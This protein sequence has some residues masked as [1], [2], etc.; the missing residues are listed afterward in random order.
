MNMLLRS[1][2]ILRHYLGI[3]GLAGL[4]LALAGLAAYFLM[5]QPAMEQASSRLQQLDWMRTHP[6]ALMRKVAKEPDAAEALDQF[7]GQFPRAAELSATIEQ[8]HKLAREHGITLRLGEYKLDAEGQGRLMRYE[9]LLPVDAGYPQL[10]G[11]IDAAERRFPTLGLKDVSFKRE[12][13]GN[14]TVQTR[15]NFVLFLSRKE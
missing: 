1:I 10:R 2:S 13:V 15:L 4:G 11:F 3:A 6:E 7:Y 14:R 12:V 5:V 8:L 9:I